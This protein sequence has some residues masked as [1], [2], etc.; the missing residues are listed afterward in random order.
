[1]SATFEHGTRKSESSKVRAIAE[2][3]DASG[4]GNLL[5]ANVGP[6]ERVA[7]FASGAVLT[8]LGLAARTPL[9]KG[10]A[11]VGAGLLFRGATGRCLVYKALG[12]DT[13]CDHEASNQAVIPARQGV[14]VEKS[15]TVSCPAEELYRLWRDLEKLPRLMKHLQ[16]V[17]VIDNVRSHWVA[18]GALGRKVEWDA[19]IF[20]DRPG[21]IIAWRSLEGSQ[22]DTAGSVRFKQLSHDRGTEVAVSLKYDPPAGKLGD[23]AASLFG[24]GLQQQVADDLRAFKQQME[25]GEIPRA[26]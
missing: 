19:E 24:Q 6:A 18:K 22:V 15:V 23:F 1:M 4:V 11:A 8:G 16:R 26:E 14:K 10:V 9:G 13:A 21:E 25:T 17:E 2:S 3:N 7:S 20:N 12:I 5:S